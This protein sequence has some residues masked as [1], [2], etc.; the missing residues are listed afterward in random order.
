VRSDL[1][2]EASA[3]SLRKKLGN[4]FR[5]IVLNTGLLTYIDQSKRELFLRH[6]DAALKAGKSAPLFP[7]KKP[8]KPAPARKKN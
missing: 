4:A 7:P 3:E 2:N 5:P 1:E 8:V 6:W